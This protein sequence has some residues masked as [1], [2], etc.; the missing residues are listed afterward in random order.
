M[1][2]LLLAALAGEKMIAPGWTAPVSAVY[3]AGV[4]RAA[5]HSGS[6]GLFLKSAAGDAQGYAAAQRIRADAYRGKRIRLSG[7]LRAEPGSDGGALW[8]RV[9]MQNGDYILDGMLD[10]APAEWRQVSIVAPVPAD[11]T[12]ISFGLRMKGKG[13]IQADDFAIEEVPPRTLTTTIERRKDPAAKDIP[14]RYRGAS[15]RP[16]NLNFEQR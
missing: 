14:S 6:A 16:A 11:A 12:G 3:Q 13:V 8:L 10:S 7:W 1:L 9:E 4:D 5:A 2:L 15:A